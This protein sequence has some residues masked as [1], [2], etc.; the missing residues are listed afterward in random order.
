MNKTFLSETTELLV[1]AFKNY[2]VAFNCVEN[3]GRLN[4]RK[5]CCAFLENYETTCCVRHIKL[6]TIFLC[7]L[8]FWNLLIIISVT[9]KIWYVNLIYGLLSL[10]LKFQMFLSADIVFSVFSRV[11]HV[12]GPYT[13]FFWAELN[14]CCLSKQVFSPAWKI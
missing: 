9:E 12:R 6:P 11:C 14:T 5:S 10:E 4:F 3:W 1:H 13:L 2:K 7:I 8:H